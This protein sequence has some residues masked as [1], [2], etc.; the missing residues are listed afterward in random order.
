[1]KQNGE[2]ESKLNT[3]KKARAMI[4][5]IEGGLLLME[6]KQDVEVFRDI[7][8]IIQFEYRI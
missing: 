6:N 5:T 4:A 8:E 1:M 2:F 3:I 7:I